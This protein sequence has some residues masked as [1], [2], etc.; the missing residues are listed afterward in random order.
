[1][2]KIAKL[3]PFEAAH[4]LI[5]LP[6][7]HKCSRPHGHSYTVMLELEARDLDAHGFVVDYG[8][9]LDAFAKWVRDT[10]DHRDL[11]EVVNK[12]TTVE[13]ISRW[14]YEIWKARIPKLAAVRLSETPK[15][16]CEYRPGPSADDLLGHCGPGCD[17]GYRCECDS[18]G[19]RERK[20]LAGEGSTIKRCAAYLPPRR[21]P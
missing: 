10:L 13:N 14:I 17:D 1:M 5:D 19:V 11:N 2:Y 8:E 4:S 21:R 7:E 12:A 6:A 18:P 3:F 15:T 16:W 20:G 9:G